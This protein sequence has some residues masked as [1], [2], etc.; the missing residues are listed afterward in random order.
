MAGP[1]RAASSSQGPGGRTPA[2]AF[3]SSVASASAALRAA[4]AHGG[5]A[6]SRASRRRPD[7]APV[8]PSNGTVGR[9]AARRRWRSR[10]R[11]R[12]ARCP[13]AG[14]AHAPDASVKKPSDRR[15]TACIAAIG[16][17]THNQCWYLVYT[18]ASF[19]SSFLRHGTTFKRA[20]DGRAFL[21]DRAPSQPRRC[22]AAAACDL[23]RIQARPVDVDRARGSISDRAPPRGRGMRA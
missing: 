10:Y 9:R 6:K 7:V 18:N 1:V 17:D 13:S 16:V 11:Q 19:D 21:F 12:G 23:L 3:R 15:A 4:N 14:A 22:D 8:S 5:R 2:G 20:P